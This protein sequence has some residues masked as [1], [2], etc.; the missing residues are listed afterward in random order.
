MEKKRKKIK[1]E[2]KSFSRIKLILIGS[3][4][5]FVISVLTFSIIIYSAYILKEMFLNI[6]F[7]VIIILIG[8]L[9]YYI[10]IAE[11]IRYYSGKTTPY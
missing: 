2:A 7:R 4:L 3:A 1:K 5:F 10:L 11:F 6:A 8:I 9:T